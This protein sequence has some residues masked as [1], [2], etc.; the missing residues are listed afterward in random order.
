[1]VN[2]VSLFR[3]GQFYQMSLVTFAFQLEFGKLLVLVWYILRCFKFTFSFFFKLL[4]W[5]EKSHIAS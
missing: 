3:S 2:N 1:M 4:N 5:W